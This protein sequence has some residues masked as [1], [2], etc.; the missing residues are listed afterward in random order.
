MKIILS[1]KGFDSQNGG[2][3]SPIFPDGAFCSL[4]IPERGNF[5][6]MSD[7]RWR[8][9]DLGSIV[10][11]LTDKQFGGVHLDPDLRREARPRKRGWLPMFGQVDRGQAH[12]ENCGV[13]LGDIFLFFGWF[14]RTNKVKNR[15][16]YDTRAPHLHVIFGWLRVGSVLKPT[17]DKS[18]IPAW[19][20]EHPHVAGADWRRDNNTVYVASPHL[21]LRGLQKEIP[22]GGVFPKM[23]ATLRLTADRPKRGIWRLPKWLYPSK[24]RPPLSYHSDM[25]RWTR[26]ARG[27]L[28]ETVARGQEFVLDCDYYPEAIGWLKDILANAL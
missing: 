27:V 21:N 1:R 23:S 4:P 11:E 9:D 10:K 16:V 22:G 18:G 5:P 24:R 8:D 26:D 14:R 20:K 25:E 15:L 17:R 2:W 6:R 28:L 3:P 13:G 19:A 7:I 12:L